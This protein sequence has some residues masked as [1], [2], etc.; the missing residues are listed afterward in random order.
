MRLLLAASV[1]LLVACDTTEIAQQQPEVNS[2]AIALYDERGN[3]VREYRDVQDCHATAIRYNLRNV[4][5]NSEL[6]PVTRS[7]GQTV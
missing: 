3:F 6:L 4:K 1:I 5:E 2:G 7:V